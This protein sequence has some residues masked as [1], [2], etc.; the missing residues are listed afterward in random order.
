MSEHSG[1]FG[2]EIRVRQVTVDSISQTPAVILQS[3][4]GHASFSL[5]MNVMDASAIIFE[6]E[7]MD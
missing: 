3:V 5:Y 2:T 1:C 6:M 4:D 7:E